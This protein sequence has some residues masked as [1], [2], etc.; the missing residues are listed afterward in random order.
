MNEEELSSF[1]LPRQDGSRWVW[2]TICCKAAGL[3][4]GVSATLVGHVLRTRDADLPQIVE[5]LGRAV[6]V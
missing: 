5:G 3:L 1:A 4:P 2:V 6:T